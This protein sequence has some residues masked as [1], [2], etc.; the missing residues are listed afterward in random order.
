MKEPQHTKGLKLQSARDFVE[1][2]CKPKKLWAFKV[3]LCRVKQKL[4]DL[5][6]DLVWFRQLC[7]CFVQH[8]Q[9]MPSKMK[10]RVVEKLKP[11]T[12]KDQMKQKLDNTALLKSLKPW[13]TLKHYEKLFVTLVQQNR[14][15]TDKPSKPVT[16]QLSKQPEQQSVT[17][18]L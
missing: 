4:R 16:K 10:K 8:T 2:M 11:Q 18:L 13:A 1:R 9:A 7:T 15:P 6:P 17:K 14:P 3:V 12:T 5:Q